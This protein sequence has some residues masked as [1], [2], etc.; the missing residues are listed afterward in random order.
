MKFGQMRH[1]VVLM[2]RKGTVRN[3]MNEEVPA[4]EVYHPGLNLLVVYEDN[5]E[6]GV[7]YWRTKG[8]GNAEVV[9]DRSGRAYAH[10]LEKSEYA[11]WAEVK[12]TTGREYEEMQKIRAETTYNVH[13]RFLPGITHDMFILHHGKKLHIESILDIEERH[14]ELTVV[15]SE[16]QR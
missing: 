13:M 4:Y 12:P 14:K 15:C 3:S 11:Y 8:E 1:R 10:V 2:K 6:Q 7:V 9:K 16:V 5:D